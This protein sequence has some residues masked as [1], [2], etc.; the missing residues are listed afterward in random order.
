MMFLLKKNT[1]AL[2]MLLFFNRKWMNTIPVDTCFFFQITYPKRKFRCDLKWLSILYMWCINDKESNRIYSVFVICFVI[3]FSFLDDRVWFHRIN[4]DRNHL[5]NSSNDGKSE[6]S[7][8]NTKNDTYYFYL[9][10]W[11]LY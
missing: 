9:H 6:I 2:V 7:V 8:C 10:L 3:S 1:I 11:Y 5:S 4:C